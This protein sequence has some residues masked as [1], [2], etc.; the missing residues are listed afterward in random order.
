[1]TTENSRELILRPLGPQ[2]PKVGIQ[3]SEAG[4]MMALDFAMGELTPQERKT[5]KGILTAA[6]R[7]GLDVVDCPVLPKEDDSPNNY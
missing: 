1:M 4:D 5:V 2:G 6:Q 3:I 7:A